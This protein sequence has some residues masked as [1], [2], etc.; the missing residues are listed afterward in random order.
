MRPGKY[1]LIVLI[2]LI[3]IIFFL[4]GLLPGIINGGR[5]V[6][7]NSSLSNVGVIIDDKYI[8]N[9]LIDFLSEKSLEFCE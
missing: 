5:Y 9:T 1:I 8:G 2:I 6:S 7:F 4:L 3:L